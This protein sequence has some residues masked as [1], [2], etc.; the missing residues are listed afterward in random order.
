VQ[1]WC[2]RIEMQCEQAFCDHQWE[3][4]VD[5]EEEEECLACAGIYTARQGYGCADCAAFICDDCMKMEADA[6]DDYKEGMDVEE[7]L[8][9]LQMEEGEHKSRL[10]AERKSRVMAQK[11]PRVMA[12]KESRLM[13]QKKS[14][15][16]AQKKSRLMA[17]KKSRVMA[18]KKSRVMAQKK[19]RVMA[20]KK[21]R[22]KLEKKSRIKLEKKSRSKLEKKSRSKLEKKSRVMVQKKSRTKVLKEG[23][24]DIFMKSETIEEPKAPNATAPPEGAESDSL[25]AAPAP[26]KPGYK[27]LFDTLCFQHRRFQGGIDD[28]YFGNYLGALPVTLA[29]ISDIGHL[30]KAVFDGAQARLQAIGYFVGY[31]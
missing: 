8:E 25:E 15:V 16:M 21:S 11:K 7:D 22:S 2:R 26:Y 9:F 27:V 14:R 19:S 13:A 3:L 18:Q 10:R 29:A 1:E 23:G 24:E 4:C 6:S 17:Q 20:Q 30:T 28:E 12:Q 5:F 31:L